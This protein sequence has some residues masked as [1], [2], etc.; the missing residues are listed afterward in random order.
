MDAVIS[1]LKLLSLH[2]FTDY[3]GMVHSG[4]AVFLVEPVGKA[5]VIFVPDSRDV[6]RLVGRE[7]SY[8]DVIIDLQYSRATRPARERRFEIEEEP[9]NGGLPKYR[10]VGRFKKVEGN[11]GVLEC[12]NLRFEKCFDGG[13]GW[14]EEVGALFY[15]HLPGED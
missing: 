13:G 12:G 9:R 10:V 4:E 11:C 8:V 1:R 5:M 14:V 6:L 3:R 15:A 2:P 7:N